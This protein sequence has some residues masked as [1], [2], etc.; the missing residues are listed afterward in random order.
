[1]YQFL[2]E[3]DDIIIFFVNITIILAVD[4]VC[5]LREILV[6]VS[7]CDFHTQLA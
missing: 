6:Y 4:E 2:I 7:W 3:T 1:M 5:H